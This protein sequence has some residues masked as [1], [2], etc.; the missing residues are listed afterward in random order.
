MKRYSLFLTFISLILIS[1]PAS[2]QIELLRDLSVPGTA[3]DLSGDKGLLDDNT[4]ADQLGGPS[5]LAWTGRGQVYLWLSDRGPKDGATTHTPRYHE[6]DLA[7]SLAEGTAPVLRRTVKLFNA[8]GKPLTGR[9]TAFDTNHPEKS[10]RFD[11]EGIALWEGKTVV[12]EEYGPVIRV[13]DDSG[14]AVSDFPVPERFKVTKPSDDEDKEQADNASGR[15]PNAGF[16]GICTDGNGGLLAIL[17]RPL[18][19][20]GAFSADGKRVGRNIR[21]LNMCGPNCKP[22]EYV[23]QLDDKSHGISEI[24][25]VGG[26]LFLTIERDGKEMKSKRVMLIDLADAT[27][28]SGVAQLPVENLPKTIQPVKKR[29]LIDLQDAK[30]GLAGKS[31]P[32]KIEGLAFGPDLEDGRRL[33]LV[34]TDNDFEADE[35]TRIWFFAI[36]PKQLKP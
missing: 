1:K 3:K 28:V 4:P 16:E 36:D 11:S 14:K 6:V 15:Q 18:I 34:A 29:T 32:E 12:S 9:S 17:Q 33:L 26:S 24:C 25:H 19:Q 21:I 10:L 8:E 2:G 20:D 35:A 7:K 30:Y 31:F 23:Y 27:D 13:F 22:R 5:G